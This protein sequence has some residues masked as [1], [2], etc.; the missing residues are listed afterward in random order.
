MTIVVADRRGA[1]PSSQSVDARTLPIPRPSA[2]TRT[3]SRPQSSQRPASAPRALGGHD[4]PGS[5]RAVS[6]TMRFRPRRRPTRPRS[7]PSSDAATVRA[8]RCGGSTGRRFGGSRRGA[9]GRDRGRSCG[10]R[11]SSGCGAGWLFAHTPASSRRSWASRRL[12]IACWEISIMASY[13]APRGSVTAKPF[14]ARN[15]NAESTPVRLFPSTK[16][17]ACAI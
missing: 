16:A 1:R 10:R 11:R 7:A 17:C 3:R 2:P 12:V 13:R 15:V 6:T 8:R 5:V 4:L 14:N 9:T